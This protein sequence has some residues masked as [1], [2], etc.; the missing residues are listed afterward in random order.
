MTVKPIPDNDHVARYCKPSAVDEHGMPTAAAF[1]RRVEESHLSV[2]WLE[3]GGTRNLVEAVHRAQ[4]GFLRR[5]Y[6]LRPNGRFAI[7]NVGLAKE[8][9]LQAFGHSLKVEHMP[10]DDDPAHAGIHGYPREH[11]LVVAAELKALLTRQTVH[12]AVP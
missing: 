6:R 4:E 9:V 10:L 5:R 1:Q 11:E 12:P 8:A 7:L 2:N 3:H